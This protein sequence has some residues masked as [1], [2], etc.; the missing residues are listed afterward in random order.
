LQTLH[1]H[2]SINA[3]T[4]TIRPVSRRKLAVSTTKNQLKNVAKP[5]ISQIIMLFQPLKNSAK[6]QLSKVF[7]IHSQ[8]F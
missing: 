4:E 6:I 2:F 5:N 7:N 3:A 8:Y 1:G